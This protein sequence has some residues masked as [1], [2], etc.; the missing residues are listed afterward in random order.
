MARAALDSLRRRR[1]TGLVTKGGTH[2]T[3][4]RSHDQ[5][6]GAEQLAHVMGLHRRAH[7]AVDTVGLGKLCQAGGLLGH[8]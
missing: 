5:R 2:R 8:G 7:D 1:H 4:A 3:N 6:V